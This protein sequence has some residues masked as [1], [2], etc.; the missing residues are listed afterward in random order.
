MN[1][2]VAHDGDPGNCE[3][4][5]RFVGK[6]EAATPADVAQNDR[7]VE[8]VFVPVVVNPIDRAPKPVEVLPGTGHM[9]VGHHREAELVHQWIVGQ[10]GV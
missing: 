7:K 9:G 4:V 8:V 6:S 3:I 1:H 5:Q 2:V 10:A